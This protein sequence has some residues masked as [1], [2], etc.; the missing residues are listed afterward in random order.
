LLTPKFPEELVSIVFMP[1]GLV[2]LNHEVKTPDI[3]FNSVFVTDVMLSLSYSPKNSIILLCFT[4]ASMQ[5]YTYWGIQWVLMTRQILHSIIL[6]CF[7]HVSMQKYTYWGIQ[8]VPKTRQIVHSI[9]LLCFTQASMQ[10]Y[11]Y[12]DIQ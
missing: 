7:T 2:L 8:W 6:L 11:T 4:H 5:K 1:C 12:W 9:I 10:K 3:N